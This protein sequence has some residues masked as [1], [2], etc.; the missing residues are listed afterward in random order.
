MRTGEEI[1]LPAKRYRADFIF[2]PVVVYFKL[3]ICG[4]QGQFL[5]S[6][7]R[8]LQCFTYRGSWSHLAVLLGHPHLERFEFRRGGLLTGFPSLFYGER[9]YPT[10]NFIDLLEHSKDVRTAFLIV[11]F[12]LFKVAPR[13]GHAM[14]HLHTVST[15][16]LIV[17]RISVGLQKAFKVLQ[18][19]CRAFFVTT[20]LVLKQYQ[21]LPYVSVGP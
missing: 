15:R 4:E 2:Y 18:H 16:E 21:V 19:L 10:L 9:L 17:R 6:L 7:K 1:I 11:I 3:S 14:Q 12:R 20:T 13:M 8:I 5:P